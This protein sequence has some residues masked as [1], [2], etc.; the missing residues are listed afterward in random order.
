[1]TTPGV[2]C[3]AGLVVKLNVSDLAR[4]TEWYQSKLGLVHDPRFDLPH[5]AQFNIPNVRRVAVGLFEA[6]TAVGTGGCVPIFVVRDVA[7][8]RSNLIAL[9]VDVSPIEAAGDG[10]QLAF[11]NDPDGNALAIRQNP[12][13]HPSPD[14]VGDQASR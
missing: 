3:E 1:M 14:R 6:P 7:S 11:F 8:D 13:S 2:V 10:V 12:D 9:G 5:F 4:S